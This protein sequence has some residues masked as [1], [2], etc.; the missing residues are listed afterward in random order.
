MD[1]MTFLDSGEGAE[2]E[3]QRIDS[4]V[5][6]IEKKNQRKTR[7]KKNQKEIEEERGRREK[8]NNN[9]NNNNNK[10]LPLTYIIAVG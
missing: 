6:L 2:E 4:T 10:E 8:Q 9:N 5:K 3:K 7:T 1:L